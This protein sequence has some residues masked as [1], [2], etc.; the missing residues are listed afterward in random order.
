MSDKKLSLKEQTARGLLWGGFSNGIQQILN[1][2]FGIWLSRILSVDDYG[3]IGILTLFTLIATTLQ[4]SGFTQALANK[5]KTTHQDF[6]AVFWCSS[7]IGITLYII[8][9]FLAP[10][11]ALFFEIPELTKLSRF[12]FLGF[13]L[14]S[15][16]TAHNAYLFKYLMVKERAISMMTGLVVS[17]ALGVS[18]AYKGYAYWGLASQSITYILVTNSLFWYFSKWRPTLRFNLSPVKELLPFSSKILVTK[19]LTHFNNHLFNVLL[20]KFYTKKDVGY[21]SQANKWNLMGSSV[22]TE[23]I[24]GVAQPVLRNVADDKERQT[25]VFSKML[26]FT[27]FICFPA[28]FGLAFIAPE[29]IV[30]ALTDKWLPSAFILQLLCIG[31]AFYPINNLFGNLIISKNRTNAYMLNIVALGIL[32][33]FTA[34]ILYP[35][36]IKTMVIAFVT[37]HISWMFIWY[38]TARKSITLT[39]IQ[40]LKETIPY[41]ITII[42]AIT[43]THLTLHSISNIYLLLVS[44]ILV[45]ATLYIGLL[46]IVRASILKESFDYIKSIFNKRYEK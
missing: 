19:L 44:K 21:F 3:M 27:S 46:F 2:F 18:L 24:Q 30:I 9:F 4:E 39:V 17:G 29:F 23:M 16:G 12:L 42:I 41:L 10:Y 6:N 33:L 40:L 14:A 1:L 43:I 45:T 15:F 28:L 7:L 32:Q 36:G 13:L 26:R 38:L 31:G 37:I 11:I 25:R 22:I 8:L 34:L 20:G 35:N 5:E